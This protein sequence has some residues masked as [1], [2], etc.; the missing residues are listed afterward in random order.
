M[1]VEQ[2]LVFRASHRAER[3]DDLHGIGIHF[4]VYQRLYLTPSQ[5]YN[6]DSDTRS[7]Q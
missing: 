1:W 6:A 7:R 3:H 2:I 5:L 4:E